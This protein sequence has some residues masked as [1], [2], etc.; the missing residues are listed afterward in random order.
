MG[1]LV[2]PAIFPSL[3]GGRKKGRGGREGEKRES[4]LSPIALPFSLPPNLLPLSTLATRADFSFCPDTY[5]RARE[6][7]PLVPMVASLRKLD[8]FL[9]NV[10]KHTSTA[11]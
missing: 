8:Q 9:S 6:K 5:R 10:Q 3:R 1:D 2:C 11:N 7:K 4:L